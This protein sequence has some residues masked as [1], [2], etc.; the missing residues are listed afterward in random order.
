MGGTLYFECEAGASGDMIV[1]ALLD[2]G[3]D[4]QVLADA[5]DSLPLEGYMPIVSQV[6]KSGLSVCDFDVRLDAVHEN[7]DHDM[8]YLYG[9][10][11]GGCGHSHSCEHDRQL[12]HERGDGEGG[13]ED[14]G[15]GHG[16]GHEHGHDRS[17]ER[18]HGHCHDGG[19]DYSLDHPH[20]HRGLPEIEAIIDAGNLTPGANALAKKI[21]G[22][23]A[24]AEAAVHGR[25]RDQ[26]H[27][28]EVGAVDSI[29][30]IVAA[31]VCLD[32]LA[33]DAVVVC[34]VAEGR[35]TVR[36]QH[37]VIPVPAP[38][39]AWILRHA[40]IPTRQ[41]PVEGELVTP[42]GAAVLA[43]VRTASALP[44]EYIIEGVGMGAGKR[45][46]PTSGIL[47]AFWIS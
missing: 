13:G 29:V 41:L 4:R 3:A 22:L 16:C 43:A 20:A 30:D 19:R 34:R 27:F 26:V 6:E 37:G 23:L 44:D 35:G 46:Y 9:T 5:L 8:G 38:A 33:P 36:C 12:A 2:L 7:Q 17:W 15:L 31:A 1:A 11:D 39:T 42:T 45:N 24:D 21:F 18:H 40:A 32:N 25:S 47:R 10:V 14:H 28:H